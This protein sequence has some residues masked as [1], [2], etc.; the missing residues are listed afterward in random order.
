MLRKATS[1]QTA[2][3][4]GAEQFMSYLR[5]SGSPRAWAAEIWNC[6]NYKETRSYITAKNVDA[7][8]WFLQEVL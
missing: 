8:D 2:K 4:F 7:S 3:D 6:K 5:E 1:L